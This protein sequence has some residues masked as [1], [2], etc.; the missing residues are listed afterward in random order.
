VE[1]KAK[2]WP[3]SGTGSGDAAAT[4]V[5]VKVKRK[6]SMLGVEGGK[7]DVKASVIFDKRGGRARDVVITKDGG[8]ETNQCGLKIKG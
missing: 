1:K 7:S 3:G 6:L 4:K 2:K 5:K 8:E